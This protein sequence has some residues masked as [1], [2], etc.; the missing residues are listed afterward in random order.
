[1]G[2]NNGLHL[3]QALVNETSWTVDKLKARTDLL[4]QEVLQKYPLTISFK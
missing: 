4:V 2:Y 3:N 1:V